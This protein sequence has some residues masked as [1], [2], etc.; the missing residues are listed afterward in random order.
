MPPPL[1]MLSSDTLSTRPAIAVG[2]LCRSCTRLRGHFA[3]L[4]IGL[5]W[6]AAIVALV[7]GCMSLFGWVAVQQQQHSFATQIDRLGQAMAAQLA[8]TV[9][10]PLLADD[11]LALQHQAQ[12]SDILDRILPLDESL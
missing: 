12:L 8:A 10:E 6:S 7:F 9:A 5:K 4:S 3:R 11:A 2:A 1:Q